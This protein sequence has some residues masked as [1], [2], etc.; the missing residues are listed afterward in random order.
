MERALARQLPLLATSAFGEYAEG[1]AYAAR[2]H[3]RGR[4][5][6]G[7]NQRPSRKRRSAFGINHLRGGEPRDEALKRVDCIETHAEAGV[8]RIHE[9]EPEATAD[10]GGRGIRRARGHDAKI[11]R[12]A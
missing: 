7:L 8:V 5:A 9:V 3:E 6:R 12:V 1:G 10:E 2:F 11:A 4:R